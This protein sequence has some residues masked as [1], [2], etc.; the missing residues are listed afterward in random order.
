MKTLTLICATLLALLAFA[1][2]AN[3]YVIAS[4]NLD[5]AVAV[6]Y[7]NAADQGG[8][9]DDFSTKELIGALFNNAQIRT[10]NRR[11][12]L[13]LYSTQA[14]FL[15]WDDNKSLFSQRQFSI[16]A[17]VRIPR[18]RDNFLISVAGYNFSVDDTAEGSVFIAIDT[19]NTLRGGYVFDQH[20]RWIDIKATG[21]NVNNNRW[22]HVA[23][24]I[25]HRTASLYLNGKRIGIRSISGHRNFWGRGTFISIGENAR[26]FVDEVGFFKDDFSEQQIGLIYKVGLQ[27]LMSIAAVDP[28]EKVTTTWGKLKER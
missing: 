5:N 11:R 6:Y 3:A 7:F 28:N 15:A 26:G 4:N 24:T 9:I 12:V 19:N 20:R 16:V 18:Q 21:R 8:L 25:N 23:F 27:N 17:W 22:R 13:A 14:S 1:T 10:V 2:N